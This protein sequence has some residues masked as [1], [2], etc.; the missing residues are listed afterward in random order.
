M[1]TIS[2]CMIVKNEE[3]VLA[4]CLDS[5][6]PLMDEIIIV[7]TGSTDR[8]KEIAANY[9]DKIYDFTWCD[10][11]SAARNFS[12]SKATMEY[13]YAPDADEYIDP[14]NQEQFAQ[15]KEFLLPEIEIV[16]MHYL[17]KDQHNTV[18]NFRN[19]LRPKLFRRL[20]TFTWIDPVH[21]TVRLDPVVFDS[22]IEIQHLPQG[23]HQKRDF[24]IFEKAYARDGCLSGRIVSMYAKELL[25]CGSSEDF[26]NAA[27]LFE[28]LYN[29]EALDEY[30]SVLAHH[31]RTQA[32]TDRF[33]SIALK[34]VA[35]NGCSEICY[36]LGAYY[37]EKKDYEEACLW[38]YNAAYE[39][40]PALNVEICGRL[41]PAALSECYSGYADTLGA[42]S[43]AAQQLRRQAEEYSRQAKEWKLPDDFD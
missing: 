22:D 8:T 7:D 16:Q 43:P 26:M 27:P 10:D 6:A 4:R 13:I 23:A 11:F 33:F 24:S 40:E 28:E 37:M 15:L 9:T 3:N 1:I 20:R 12:F 35:G 38:F 19:E 34:N 5:I 42:E 14:V 17:T 29:K 2:L 25:K 32:D 30:A 36:E 41:A 21:E 18:Q 39:T 31:Y